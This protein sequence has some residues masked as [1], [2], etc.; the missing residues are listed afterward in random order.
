MAGVNLDLD[1]TL[2][3]QL[4]IVLVLMFV[5]KSLVFDP[6]LKAVDA[7]GSQDHRDA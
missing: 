5:L 4:G 3:I 1:L 6:Y 2:F 7:S